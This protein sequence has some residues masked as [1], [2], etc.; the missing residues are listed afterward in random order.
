MS[1]Y[2]ERLGYKVTVRITKQEKKLL[3]KIA[4]V[5]KIHI[6]DI[7]KMLL[8]RY[9]YHIVTYIGTPEIDSTDNVAKEIQDEFNELNDRIETHL[10]TIKNH[11]Q[12]RLIS[13]LR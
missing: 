12:A 2:E 13:R 10:M 1:D 7:V 6:S 11:G 9:C 8:H 4:L 3:E 5:N